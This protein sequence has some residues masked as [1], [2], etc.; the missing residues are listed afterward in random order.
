MSGFQAG[1]EMGE[2]L[3]EREYGV[4][5]VR[6]AKPFATW[7]VG[8][9]VAAGAV[10]SSPSS[11]PGSQALPQPNLT[12]VYGL[13]YDPGLRLLAH[14]YAP[15]LNRFIKRSMPVVLE[16]LHQLSRTAIIAVM[17][18]SPGSGTRS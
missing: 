12:W 15:H 13:P 1:W 18:G 5:A 6:F 3:M 4:A 11:S 2:A 14:R 8:N 9:L 17:G 7:G 16:E 10:F